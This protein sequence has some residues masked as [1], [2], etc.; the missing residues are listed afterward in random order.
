M[1]TLEEDMRVQARLM[2]EESWEKGLQEGRKKGLEQGLEQ[3]M[4]QLAFLMARLLDAGRIEDA[5]R[6][7]EDPV[8]RDELLKEFDIT[9]N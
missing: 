7:A 4:E 3:G 8:L 2:Q 1:L 9:T 6:V 5:R